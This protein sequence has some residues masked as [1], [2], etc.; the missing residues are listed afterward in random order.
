VE[1]A[2]QQVTELAGT[3]LRAYGGREAIDAARRELPDVILLDLMMPE[4]NGFDVVAAL[5]EQ[6]DTAGIPILVLTAKKVTKADR[7]RLNGYVAAVVEKG[8]LGHGLFTDEVRRA[9]YGRLQVA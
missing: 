2:A 7:A 4:V 6:P 9:M 5:Q 1:L 3:V 8:S